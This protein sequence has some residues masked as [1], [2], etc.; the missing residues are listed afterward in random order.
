MNHF[1]I[2]YRQADLP[3][4]KHTFSREMGAGVAE[5]TWGPVPARGFL[6]RTG[7]IHPGAGVPDE[8]RWGKTRRQSL[9]PSS[10][11]ISLQI[12]R[13]WAQHARDQLRVSA[14][15]CVNMASNFWKETGQA[16]RRQA[17]TLEDT[18]GVKNQTA[19]KSAWLPWK[20]T[21]LPQS[22]LH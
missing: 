16:R 20:P 21:G 22:T 15:E 14:G 5:V 4:G 6:R 2:T 19:P 12:R 9:P 18:A 3:Q 17:S 10:Q 1:L 8:D 13:G 11:D 7:R